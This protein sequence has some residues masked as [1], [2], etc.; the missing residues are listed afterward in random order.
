MY[1]HLLNESFSEAEAGGKALSL[2]YML[3]K[4]FPVPNGFVINTLAFHQFSGNM[5]TDTTFKLELENA[6]LTINAKQYMVRSSAV[7]E[8]SDDASFAGQLDSFICS[9][10]PEDLLKHIKKC[11]ESRYK[12]NVKKYRYVTK[13]IFKIRKV[14]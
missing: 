6:L 10:N 5:E 1:I 7:G 8:D 11:W 9:N 4:G 3:R 2:S 12:E 14:V 13:D